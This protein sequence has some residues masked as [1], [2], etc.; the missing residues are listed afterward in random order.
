M[1]IFFI[2]LFIYIYIITLIVII[3]I[4]ILFDTI[5]IDVLM[6]VRE[7]VGKSQNTGDFPMTCGSGGSKSSIEK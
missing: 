5:T 3:V 7:K 6:Q 2:Y 1:Y 4:N